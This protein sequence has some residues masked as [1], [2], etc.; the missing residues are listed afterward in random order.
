M[1]KQIFAVVAAMCLTTA[2]V[3]PTISYAS[4]NSSQSSGEVV[5]EKLG[6]PI[7]VYGGS[8][9]ESEK[10]SV[11]NSLGV[12]NNS[13]IQEIT[14]TGA[15]I[16]KY[17]ENGNSSARLYS[18]AKITPKD[19]GSGLVINVVTPENITEVTADMYS[20]AML[21]AG[22]EDATVEVAAPKKVTGHS[23]LAGIYKAYEVTTGKTLDKDRTDVANQEL[24]VAT[25]IAQNSGVDNEKVSQL[26]TDIKKQ[27]AEQN[28]ATK[29]DV[30]KIVDEQLKKLEINL[31]DKDRQLLIDLMN[32]ISK[33]DIDFSKWSTQLDDLSGHIKD[34]LGKINEDIK[35]DSGFWASVK[36]FFQKIIDGISSI[37]G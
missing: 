6:V 11:K 37:F 17:I 28:P 20:N 26:L 4:T 32:K 35:S 1:K 19:A 10:A 27:I 13:D 24:S 16:A 9:S 33:L 15:D 34:Q 31:S 29:A 12:T 8:L 30:E 14:I 36:S 23:A 7:V 18:S 5:N 2:V 3:A 25:D 22:I 21:T